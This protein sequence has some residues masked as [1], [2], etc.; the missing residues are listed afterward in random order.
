[1]LEEAM[2]LLA[3]KGGETFVDAT[4]GAGGHAERIAEAIGKTGTLVGVDQDRQILPYAEKSLAG[5]AGRL[6]LIH[7]NFENLG[8]ILKGLK[9]AAVDGILFDLGV[10][11][12]QLESGE[13][14]FSFSREGPLDMRMNQEMAHPAEQAINRLSE[15]RLTEILQ[16]YGEE[17][18]ARRIARAI[19]RARA[20][21][22]IATT[23]RLVN[24][25]MAAAPPGR[26]RIHPATRT[27]MALRIYVNRE[28]ECLER[29]LG[30]IEKFLNPG[31]RLVVI[32]FHSLE[33]RIVKNV[34]RLKAQEGKMRLLVKKPLTPTEEERRA[35][36]RSRSAKMRAAERA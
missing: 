29:A 36:P 28:L 1:M 8:E 6:E 11:S 23:S 9:I 7:G 14:G 21:A 17:R 10:S 22:R 4:I 18:W 27:F 20:K 30:E 25:I 5:F 16:T 35:N 31:G 26:W 3:P 32:A 19:V 33:D 12:L 2:R 15:K 24:A 13:R 34:L